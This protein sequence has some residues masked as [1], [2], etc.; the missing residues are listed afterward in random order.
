[1]SRASSR[2]LAS[3]WGS[4]TRCRSLPRNGGPDVSKI[5][6]PGI[7]SPAK[8]GRVLEQPRADIGSGPWQ[9]WP[10]EDVPCSLGGIGERCRKLW[11][12][13]YTSAP[14][15]GTATARK[16]HSPKPVTMDTDI[17]GFVISA[18]GSPVFPF[19]HRRLEHTYIP[20]HSSRPSGSHCKS[21]PAVSANP[22]IVRFLP[23]GG[24]IG[25]Q[26]A[27]FPWRWARK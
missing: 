24:R 10:P 25:W 12:A 14:G 6:V 7:H 15:I 23:S 26:T 27:G 8:V 11:A 1:M 18:K 5:G 2:H 16:A 13:W 20:S 19:S 21:G 22:G 3:A 17:V 9:S 4:S